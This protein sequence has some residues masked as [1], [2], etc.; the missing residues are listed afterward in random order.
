MMFNEI[1]TEE[2]VLTWKQRTRDSITAK[3]ILDSVNPDG[4][5]LTT[6]EWTYPRFIHSEIMTHRKL[7]RNS[8]SS[9]AIPLMKMID[10]IRTNPVFQIHI[11]RNQAGMQAHEEVGIEEQIAYGNDW[12]I[13]CEQ[14]IGAV[15]R[16]HHWG[17]HKQNANRRLEPWMYIT[18][19][20]S[21]TNFENLFSLRVHKDAE[22]HFQNLAGKVMKALD[23]S[24]PS[25]IE[26]GE[27]HL[28]LIKVE[29]RVEDLAYLNLD[30]SS[31]NPLAAVSAAKCGRVSYLTHE[32][33]R[34]NAEDYKLYKKLV[35]QLPKHSSPLEHPAQATNVKAMI[36]YPNEK[37][38]WGNFDSGWLQLRKFV[39][40]ENITTRI[41]FS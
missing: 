25:E 23:D 26:W 38:D 21:A 6:M 27:W 29:D 41:L 12:L 35:A 30:N 4:Q 39:E 17:I 37:V 13:G 24:L 11:G 34:D 22:Y 32:G 31:P 40:D 10:R 20:C 9:R 7:S 36:D 18:I 28:P 16:A 1:K 19:I 5:R 33:I 8:A 2:D 15:L 14:A 3:V